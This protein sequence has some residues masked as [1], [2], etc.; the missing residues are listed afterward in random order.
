MMIEQ[1]HLLYCQC[2]EGNL[3]A[4]GVLSG[5]RNF[6]GRIHPLTRANYLASPPL[7][8]AYALAGSVL[9][10]FDTEPIGQLSVLLTALLILNSEVSSWSQATMP[11]DRACITFCWWSVVT[12]NDISM[13][14]NS[15]H[16]LCTRF[17]GGSIKRWCCLTSVAYIRPKSRTERPRKTKFGTIHTPRHT[18]PLHHFQGQKVTGSR[19]ILWRPPAYSLLMLK[20]WC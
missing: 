6:E 11:I 17:L 14:H 2:V 4:V 1:Y 9:V 20:R 5:N 10:D 3:V 12:S 8:I 13:F 19:G 16:L 15:A 18:W 7:V